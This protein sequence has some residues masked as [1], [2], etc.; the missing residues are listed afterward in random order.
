[1]PRS[2]ILQLYKWNARGIRDDEPVDEVG[3]A[4][5]ARVES[6]LTV[7]SAQRGEVTCPGCGTIILR[8]AAP[9]SGRNDRLMTCNCG[10]QM[11]YQEYRRT[12][13]NKH[14]GCAGMLKPCQGFA[15]ALPKTRTYTEKMVAI[16]TLMHRFHWELEG[17]AAQPG[18][19]VVIG[20]KMAEIGD[21]LDMLT[22]G[23][24]STAGVI[25]RHESWRKEATG[26]AYGP[27]NL[28][29]T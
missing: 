3:Y 14:L 26:K 23:D 18:A 7:S 13:H 1:V 8:G 6:C 20:G 5:L 11:P 12:F 16:D 17:H 25:A 21:F 2:K 27:T 29:D 15:E 24:L 9:R 22:R 4:L 19:T 28:R 10:W